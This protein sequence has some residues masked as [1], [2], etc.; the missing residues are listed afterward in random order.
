[1]GELVPKTVS[2]ARAERVALLVARPSTGSSIPFDGR[3]IFSKESPGSS[4]K[5]LGV[6]TRGG[7]G[8]AHSTEELQ[9]QIQQARE[10]GLLAAGERKVHFERELS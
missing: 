5:A 8:V 4:V 1:L 6:S 10:R 2:L 7:H 9:M 3:L